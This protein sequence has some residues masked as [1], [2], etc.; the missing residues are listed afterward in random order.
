LKEPEGKNDHLR[1]AAI[2]IVGESLSK[3]PEDQRGEV[4]K[5]ALE[6]KDDKMLRLL[7]MVLSSVPE[8]QRGE[9]V[10]AAL[11][12]KDDREGRL[13]MLVDHF[14]DVP[15]E[16]REAVVAE[17]K[18]MKDDNLLQNLERQQQA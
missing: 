15:E 3:L 18:A 9:V 14:D 6:I 11:A 10:Q 4:L 5:E 2:F 16:Y 7:L 12:T 8:D 1:D 13:L 17:V